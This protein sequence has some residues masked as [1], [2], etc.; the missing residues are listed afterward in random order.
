MQIQDVVLCGC[1]RLRSNLT[2][3]V[4]ISLNVCQAIRIV[5]R[6]SLL[7]SFTDI[8]LNRMKSFKME[9]CASARLYSVVLIRLS[10]FQEGYSEKCFL[11]LWRTVS[12]TFL[13]ARIFDCTELRNR[14]LNITVTVVECLNT[15][16]C[17]NSISFNC[18]T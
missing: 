9:G 13:T 8:L 10:K 7:H 2:L 1:L 11:L 17:I 18:F 12:C 3:L 4:L 5:V 15:D 6:S 16:S 14:Y